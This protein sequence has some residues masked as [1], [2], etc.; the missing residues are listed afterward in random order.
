MIHLVGLS[1]R[2]Q[3][4]AV[5]ED[6]NAEV[7]TGECV[8]VIGPSG[9][10][11]TVLFRTIARL[12]EPGAGSIVID[13]VDITA[14]GVNVNTVRQK[15]GMVYQGFH[16]FSHLTVIDNITLAPRKVRGMSREEAEKK[17]LELLALV[18]LVQKARAFPH[19]LSG[20]Q[21]QRVAIARCLAM[22]PQILMF[23]EPT[24]ALDPVMTDEVLSVIKRL[25]KRGLTI[26][27]S[28]HEM[29]FA[30]EV[31]DR[32]LYMDEGGIYEQGT[33]SEIFDHPQR[34]KTRTFLRKLNVFK[35]AIDSHD[36]DFIGMSSAVADFCRKHRMDSSLTYRV[37]LVLE[38]MIV[39]VLSACFR[40][41]VPAM[42]YTIESE[43]GATI[44]FS[45]NAPPYDPLAMSGGGEEQ[46][47]MVLVRKTAATYKHIFTHGMNTITITL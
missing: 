18:G 1:K 25:V 23:D 47:G 8:A 22:D 12:E 39:Q 30:R 26:L 2:Y 19:Q 33:P 20:G 38:E 16:L 17:A 37:Q 28:T 14:K 4:V 6:L 43:G 36:F 34:E 13:G 29:E 31:A 45:F 10:G 40:N 44:E 35:Y 42:E 27:I 41:A 7:R 24:S 32:V 15:M 11:K 21:Q 9:V 5:F 3:D 46:L